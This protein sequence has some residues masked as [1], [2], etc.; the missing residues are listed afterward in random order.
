MD[1]ESNTKLSYYPQTHGRYLLYY[2]IYE[3]KERHQPPIASGEHAQQK[4]YE[5]RLDYSNLIKELHLLCSMMRNFLDW[6]RA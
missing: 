5:L 1:S 4:R 3:L 2:F 6:Q